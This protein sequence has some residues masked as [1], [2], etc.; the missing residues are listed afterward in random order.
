M[1]LSKLKNI[2][3]TPALNLES[4]PSQTNKLVVLAP[5]NLIHN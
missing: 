5:K 1:K 2:T 4:L 3:F